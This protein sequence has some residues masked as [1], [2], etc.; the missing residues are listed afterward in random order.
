MFIATVKC[1]L[2]SSQSLKIYM[3]PLTSLLP[4]NTSPQMEECALDYDLQHA[5]CPRSHEHCL[6]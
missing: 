6:Q 3:S 5:L 2:V 4:P 1:P